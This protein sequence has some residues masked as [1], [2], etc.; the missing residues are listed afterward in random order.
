MLK[1]MKKILLI[2]I[3]FILLFE[4][5]CSNSISYASTE[6]IINGITNL[7]GGIVSII[8]WPMRALATAI[9]LGINIL[10]TELA[11]VS[12]IDEDYSNDQ[13]YFITPY[14]IFFNKYNLLDVNFFEIDES[15]NDF[16]NKLKCAV[17][18]WYYIVRLIASVILLVILIY[19]GIRMAL[20][21][22]AS[23]KVK[24]RKM[25]FDWLCSIALVFLMHYIIIFVIYVNEAIVNALSQAFSGDE[26]VQDAI[27]KLVGMGVVGI[28]IPNITAV[29]VF[30]MLTFQTIAFLIAYVNRM[31]KVAFLIIISPLIT[32]TYSIDKMGDG[33]A[34]AFGNW[35]K[36]FVYTILIQPFHCII[37]YTFGSVAFELFVGNSILDGIFNI[38]A[39]G[40]YNY[41]I[42]GLLAVFCLKFINDG[43][44][45][46][47]NI[48]GFQD[49][50]RTGASM[51]VGA[52]MGYAAVKHA[53]KFGTG[54]RKGINMAKTNLAKFGVDLSGAK[55]E[56]GRL[57]A[58]AGNKLGVSMPSLPDP[59]KE[60][61]SKVSGKK[62]E[63]AGKIKDKKRTISNVFNK[64]PIAPVVYKGKK[65]GAWM[66]SKNK[67]SLGATMGVIAGMA[68]YATGSTSAMEAVGTGHATEKVVTAFSGSSDKKLAEDVSELASDLD[69]KDYEELKAR[70]EEKKDE[71]QDMRAQV[72]Q[73]SESISQRLKSMNISEKDIENMTDLE[74][75]SHYIKAME[76]REAARNLYIKNVNQ[77]DINKLIDEA[78]QE[79]SLANDEV[80]LANDIKK[81]NEL[82]ESISKLEVLETT[83]NEFF[84]Q[85]AAAARMK[86]RRKGSTKKEVKTTIQEIQMLLMENK[87]N[88]KNTKSVPE[89]TEEETTDIL[90]TTEYMS[91]VLKLAAKKRSIMQP[92]EIQELTR[93]ATGLTESDDEFEKI[94]EQLEMLFTHYEKN[95]IASIYQNSN[96]QF[97]TRASALD[98]EIAKSANKKSK[99]KYNLE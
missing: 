22:V 71:L 61:L 58:N 11:E 97:K 25:F 96:S 80:N 45:I 8:F 83:Y 9:T 53:T 90:D 1:I 99:K 43:E 40:E 39:T 4:F 21:T 36:E 2:F 92:E 64:T 52:A 57:I 50:E 29:I 31:L 74:N 94:N 20:S 68:A 48:F 67:N 82:Q 75:N 46:V 87:R 76:L 62:Q 86:L 88:S 70:W 51:A 73:I 37:Y 42:N 91:N 66:M 78:D 7:G 16:S 69:K 15:K 3:I 34:Q 65:F 95:E 6:D 72:Q 41:L 18:E 28:G 33:K 85:K 59:L 60:N 79:E 5:S 26:A 19:V 56:A 14:E 93:N 17:S 55:S 13:T 30:I 24:Y 84:T 49:D 44:K 63:I 98:T 12:G 81:R 23:D 54:A 27:L 35:L 32:I 89:L 10:T 77:Q 47:R 38:G